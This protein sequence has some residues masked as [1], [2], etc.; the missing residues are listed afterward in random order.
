MRKVSAVEIYKKT[1]TNGDLYT[2]MPVTSNVDGDYHGETLVNFN[3][4]MLISVY[5]DA[6]EEGNLESIYN[7]HG[8]AR[9]KD[10]Y[11]YMSEDDESGREMCEYSILLSSEKGYIKVNYYDGVRYF[12]LTEKCMDVELY[13]PRKYDFE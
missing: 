12:R 9:I 5:R 7:T 10:V 4:G 6:E 2:L 1:N 11:R 3:L 13:K 8:W